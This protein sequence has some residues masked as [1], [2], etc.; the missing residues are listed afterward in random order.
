M[1]IVALSAGSGSVELSPVSLTAS[2]AKTLA[3]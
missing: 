2:D 1:E 3:E